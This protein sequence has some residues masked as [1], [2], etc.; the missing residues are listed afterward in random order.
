MDQKQE[1]NNIERFKSIYS[2]ERIEKYG[3]HFGPYCSWVAKRISTVRCLKPDIQK[4]IESHPYVMHAILDIQNKKI[5]I[6]FYHTIKKLITENH[7]AY[8]NVKREIYEQLCKHMNETNSDKL[9]Q[10]SFN[11][12]RIGMHI[13]YVEETLVHEDDLEFNIADGSD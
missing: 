7:N 4:L 5:C 12:I 1:I 6:Y 3:E 2:T 11:Q 8:I 9:N 13:L 10:K